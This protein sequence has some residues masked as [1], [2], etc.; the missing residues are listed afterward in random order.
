MAPAPTTVK[1]FQATELEVP[2]ATTPISGKSTAEIEP[3]CPLRGADY[4]SITHFGRVIT[5]LTLSK[6]YFEEADQGIVEY[7]ELLTKENDKKGIKVN[8]RMVNHLYTTQVLG[9][10]DFGS[11]MAEK[12]L[13]QVDS[14]C[15][16]SGLTSLL[17][18]N[19]LSA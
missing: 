6:E 10:W 17:T 1:A 12:L 9:S 13:S 14:P 8:E 19:Q 18:V 16:R 11:P 5:T 7:S 15:Q 2:I 3:D 4:D